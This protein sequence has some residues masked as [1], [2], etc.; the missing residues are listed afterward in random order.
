MDGQGRLAE[1]LE[2]VGIAPQG[3]S[4]TRDL[5]GLTE[6]L[7]EDPHLAAQHVRLHGRAD[8]VDRAERIAARDVGVIAVGGDEDD[9]RVLGGGAFAD[10]RRG[11]EAVETGHGDVEQNDG[12]FLLQ[13][14]AQRLAA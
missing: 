9:R 6:E 11:F 10:Q 12:D 8:E 1:L 13:Q 4:L 7:D 3:L 14:A 5:L 2:L